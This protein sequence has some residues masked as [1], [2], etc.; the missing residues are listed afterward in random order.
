MTTY[1]NLCALLWRRKLVV[2]AVLAIMIPAGL[3]LTIR[4][5][6]RYESHATVMIISNGRYNGPYDKYAS[7]SI[8][9][10]AR[11]TKATPFLTGVAHRMSTPLAPASIGNDLTVS[12]VANTTDFVLTATSARP[13][14]SAD[15]VNAA[16]DQMTAAI[17]ADGHF[18]ARV[19]DPGRAPASAAG[20]GLI[21]T[22]IAMLIG[23]VLIAAAA[24]I[25]W[26]RT[27]PR[28]IDGEGLAADAGADVVG[29][30]PRTRRSQ[31][32]VVEER[33][34]AGIEECLRALRTNMFFHPNVR[35]AIVVVGVDPGSGTSAVAAN[36]AVCLAEVNTRVLLVD[37]DLRHPRQH[38]IFDLGND[39]GLS[40]VTESDQPVSEML[41]NTAYPGLRV[42]TSGPTP[43]PGR[44]EADAY[45]T[46]GR[47]LAGLAEF[48]IVDAPPLSEVADARLLASS[49][50]AA[51]LVVR[52][53]RIS[54][55]SVRRATES[56]RAVGCEVAGTVL[57]GAPSHVV[58]RWRESYAV[59]PHPLPTPAS[60]AGRPIAETAV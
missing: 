18:S 39:R 37:A 35:D 56:L 38:T 32:V 11:L 40:T 26:D 51:L 36:L 60:D 19:A 24:A 33:S 44:D 34:K 49:V 48:T 1:Q 13:K 30:L 16:A 17:Q 4:E 9:T 10:Y 14:L 59:F 58:S 23:A 7:T 15:I 20:P 12:P 46:A 50:G 41:Q 29:V 5:S 28:V 22:G 45:R 3:L 57:T 54:P 47:R 53:G 43:S 8:A 25:L 2:G 52:A 55:Q 6:R 31:G 27:A 21:G 42:L